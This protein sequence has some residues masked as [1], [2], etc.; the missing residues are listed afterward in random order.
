MRVDRKALLKY[1]NKKILKLDDFNI[2]EF[3]VGGSEAKKVDGAK[4]DKAI[5]MI[6]EMAST[7]IKLPHKKLSEVSNGDTFAAC[8]SE[9]DEREW[10]AK[11][12]TTKINVE[13]TESMG[14]SNK[15]S[16]KK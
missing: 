15:A 7:K 1:A 10:I 16:S 14:R 9:I 2:D 12:G 6:D 13:L 3:I 8:P 5:E 4:T 11:Y